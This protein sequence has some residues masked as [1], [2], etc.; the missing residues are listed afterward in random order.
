MENK[1]INNQDQEINNVE[2]FKVGR[3]SS[4]E[5][6]QSKNDDSS[7]TEQENEFAD[8]KGTELAEA[9]EDENLDEAQ[10]KAENKGE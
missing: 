8:G 3:S 6:E 5:V 2:Q 1:N 4:P 7:Y 10:Q 9:F